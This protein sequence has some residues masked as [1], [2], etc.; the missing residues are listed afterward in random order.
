MTGPSLKSITHAVVNLD[1][2]APVGCAD[3]QSKPV[4]W[5]MKAETPTGVS[6]AF[7]TGRE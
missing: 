1:G 4:R 6:S 2:V 5:R 7:A 3:P